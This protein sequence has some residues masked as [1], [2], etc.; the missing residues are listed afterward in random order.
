MR[1]LLGLFWALVGGVAGFIVGALGASIYASA[2]NMSGREGARGYFMIV[3]GLIGAVVGIVS[4]LVLYGRSAPSGQ[5]VAYSGSGTLGFV[6]LVAAIALSFWAFMQLREAPLEYGGSF[7]SLEMEFRAKTTDIRS[8]NP[9]TWLNV[10]VQSGKTRPEGDVRW[11]SRRIDGEYTIIPVSQG[12]LVRS[13][14]RV[15]MV[16]V[17]EQ[18]VE[19][20]MP[21]IKRTP[22]PKAD[23]SEWYRPGVVDP[24]YGVT[25]TVPLKPV[26]EMR[27]KISVYGQ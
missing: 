27:Y 6:A 5:A 7:A 15:I 25:P 24:P 17:G 11:S 1:I 23:W 19:A 22:D 20:F 26:L 16:R 13:G 18:Q 3:I 10:E 14:S 12:P 9:K 8:D 2:T 4:G 21:P